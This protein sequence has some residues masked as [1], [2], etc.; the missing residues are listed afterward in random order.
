MPIYTKTGD[1]GETGMIG[2]KRVSKNDS[3]IQAIGD[4]DELNAALGMQGALRQAP[5]DRSAQN[6]KSIQRN[7]QQIQDDIFVI[8]AM[9]ADPDAKSPHTPKLNAS[10]I[11]ALE[12]QIDAWE[13]ILPPLKNFILPGGTL[14]SAH[15]HLARAICRRA[16]RS[17]IGLHKRSPVPE[18]ILKYMNRLSDFLFVM[19][20]MEMRRRKKKERIWKA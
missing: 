6:E 15:A 5:G 2:G 3:R 18:E 12:K 17:L 16:E 20:R 10:R 4:L 19:A 7:I 13:K 11:T 8:G 1:N 9:L 14:F